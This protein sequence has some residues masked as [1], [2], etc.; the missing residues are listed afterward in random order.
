MRA[1]VAAA[2][3][4]RELEQLRYPIIIARFPCEALMHPDRV[5]V[6]AA[7]GPYAVLLGDGLTDRLGALLDEHAIGRRRFVVTN[8]VVWRL[9]GERIAEGLPGAEVIH[10]PDGERHKHLATIA[11]IYEA[12]VR[13]Q[14]D[15]GSVIIA[16]GGGVIGD[17]AGFAAATF[18]RGIGLVQVP[19]T[20]L[21]QVDAS[22]GGKTGVNLPAGKNLVG[23]FYPPA[24]V[25]ADPLVLTTL[26]RREFRAGLYEVIKYGMA[27][28]AALFERLQAEPRLADPR[29]AKLGSIIADCCRIK[30]SVVSADERESG[31]RRVLN[32]GHTAG[33]AIEALTAYR[34]F[35][36]G[37]AVG[38]GMLVASR[39]AV[40]RGALPPDADEALRALV[41]K[42]GPLPNVSDLQA[43]QLVDAM[44]RDKKVIDGTLHVVL[45][46]AI[47]TCT[48]ADNVTEREFLSALPHVGFGE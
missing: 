2:L 10:V 21:A 35:R 22:V 31:I 9:H 39:I 33:H 43:S 8:P 5:D 28:S 30:A 47:G 16:I 7:S 14:A 41:M 18:L 12:L 23:A 27:C 45:P 11:R 13:H 42:L 20:L 6:H 19:T 3:I 40:A 17:M 38:W 48:V 1:R 44:R 46:T 26:S 34:R 24:L 36:H 25:V 15:R 32:F 29:G 37:E 4:A